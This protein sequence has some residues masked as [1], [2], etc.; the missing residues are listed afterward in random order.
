VNA[1]A[2]FSGSYAGPVATGSKADEQSQHQLTNRKTKHIN[3]NDA[4]PSKYL[5]AADLPD[6]GAISVTIEKIALEE[7]GKDKQTKPV[8]YF[9]ET[10]N[11]FICNKTNARA[12]A[13]VIG[14]EEFDDWI[15]KTIRLYRTEVDFQGDMVEAIRVKSRPDK[16]PVVPIT[17]TAPVATAKEEHDDIPF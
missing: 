2:E 17:K 3:I 5:K 6:E 13:R 16:S 1:S 12:I 11:G 7:I 8:L 14:S 4:Y 10:A 9:A 15:S